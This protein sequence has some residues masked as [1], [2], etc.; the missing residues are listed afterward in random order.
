MSFPF[1]SALLYSYDHRKLRLLALFSLGFFLVIITVIRLPINFS[2]GFQQVNRTT[3]A[4]TE[5]LTAA[6]VA[7]VPTLY[8][9]RKRAPVTTSQPETNTG[10]G[11][12]KRRLGCSRMDAER[13]EGTKVEEEGIMITQSVE[14]KE[15]NMSLTNLNENVGGGSRD[16]RARHMQDK[17]RD[18]WQKKGSS[19]EDL[20]G[21]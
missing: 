17:Y 13:S 15:M 19:E 21:I 11:T 9:L 20:V 5:A 18:R 1:T 16:N 12:R 2:H 14:L 7:K 6:I 10:S 3:W 4:S 8:T